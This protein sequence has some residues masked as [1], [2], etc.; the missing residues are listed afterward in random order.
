MRSVAGIHLRSNRVDNT[1]RKGGTS[2]SELMM[3]LPTSDKKSRKRKRA[4]GPT[5]LV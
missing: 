1:R 3:K 5:K 4:S 2:L